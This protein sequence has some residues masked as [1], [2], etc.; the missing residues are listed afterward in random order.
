MNKL[1]KFAGILLA[2]VMCFGLTCTAFASDYVITVENSVTGS[3]YN[4]YKVFDATYSGTAVAYTISAT[5]AWYDL[6]SGTTTVTDSEG[7]TI[8][9]PFTLTATTTSGTYNVSTTASDAEVAAWFNA[10]TAEQLTAADIT[11]AATTTGTGSS[12]TLD[13]GS[14]GYYYI[15][16]TTGSAVTVTTAKPT[17]SVVDKN[18]TPGGDL[19]KTA[20]DTTK[21]IGD[22]VTYTITSSVPAYDGET[23]ITNYTFVDTLS[24]GL[25]APA[26]ADVSVTIKD[27]SGATVA[28]Q[29]SVDEDNNKLIAVSVSG[30]VITVSYDPTAITGYPADATIEI[31]YTA[32]VNAQAAYENDNTGK[33]T[34]TG[35]STGTT[36]TETVYTYGFDLN[37]YAGSVAEG[38]E[39]DGAEFTL[40]DSNGDVIYFVKDGDD[41][42]VAT[43]ADA[44]GATTTISAGCIEIS[45]LAAGTYTLTETKAPDGYNKLTETISVTVGAE[46]SYDT[47]SG[48]NLTATNVVNQ[49]GSSLPSTGGIGTTIFYVVG[50][51]LVVGAV[52]LLI[53]KKRMSE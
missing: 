10:I 15:T 45:G 52:V 48:I 14:A 9:S 18:Q 8:A 26:A 3:T 5:D 23:K 17:A 7:N 6:V 24:T 50:G 12:I 51:A 38:N 37:K 33:Q 36:D 31:K 41:Y 11:A 49:A 22:T 35:D 46:G 29:D 28:T 34:W 20:D 39:L 21:S 4:A 53:T 16:T 40:S 42:R 25:T 47:E 13:V 43:S 2:L 19:D 1:K 44:E 32:T 27:A 30:Q